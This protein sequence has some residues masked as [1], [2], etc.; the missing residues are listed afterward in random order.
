MGQKILDFLEKYIFNNYK[1]V[2][3]NNPYHEFN[4]FYSEYLDA[5][6]DVNPLHQ[7]AKII[8]SRLLSKEKIERT[9]DEYYSYENNIK[10]VIELKTIFQEIKNFKLTD[11]SNNIQPFLNKLNYYYF[12]LYIVLSSSYPIIKL[13]KLEK[14]VNLLKHYNYDGENESN[15]FQQYFRGQADAKWNIIPSC[16][17]SINLDK[18]QV[19]TYSDLIDKYKSIDVY[20][21]YDR[22]ID[23]KRETYPMI[24]FFQH[25]ISFSP[26]VDFTSKLEVATFF[27][28]HNFTQINDFF[29]KNSAVFVLHNNKGD[30]KI[31]KLENDDLDNMKIG[32][33]KDGPRT[34]YDYSFMYTN[35]KRFFGTDAKTSF[36]TKRTNDRMR[37]Q[38]GSFV[39]F[40]DFIIDNINSTIITI[41]TG[42]PITKLVIDKSIKKDVLNYLNSNFPDY[43]LR[44]L[45]NPYQRFEEA[46]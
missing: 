15:E 38:S 43:R 35:M 45:M 6:I 24:S 18:T 36:S 28:L 12:L 29:N 3:D 33:Y 21:V 5:F 46:L 41:R 11:E 30:F 22:I 10:G 25:S 16:L 8:D 20:N 14:Y 44:Y 31:K 42:H 17:R 40:D 32:I 1:V 23:S 34:F 13:D 26:L 9:Y 27:A 37:Y 39:F 2:I 19:F 7:I 4:K